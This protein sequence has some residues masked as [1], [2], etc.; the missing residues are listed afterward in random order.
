MRERI[1]LTCYSVNESSY[2]YQKVDKNDNKVKYML[3]SANIK[4]LPIIENLLCIDNIRDIIPITDKDNVEN[5]YLLYYYNEYNE[6]NEA[7]Y[8]INKMM[9]DKIL[10]ITNAIEV[11][12]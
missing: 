9:Y 2:I 1:K 8:I 4:D 11:S 6:Y 3:D 5:Y 12:L 10:R 7:F